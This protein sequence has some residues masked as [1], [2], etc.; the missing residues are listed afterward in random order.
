MKGNNEEIQVF[1]VNTWLEKYL[2]NMRSRGTLVFF[3]LRCVC[4]C[5]SI[6]GGY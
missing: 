2:G 4:V 3:P 6:L 5:M 1:D